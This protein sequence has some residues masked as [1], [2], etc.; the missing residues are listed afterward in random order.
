MNSS[1]CSHNHYPIRSSEQRCSGRTCAAKAATLVLGSTLVAL[2]CLV[3]QA[4]ASIFSFSTG[5]P[6]KKIATLSRVPSPAGIQTE[7]AD[8]F[9]LDTNT[10]IT[11][12]TFTGLIPLGVS[13]A[14]ITEVEIEIYHVFPVDSAFPPSGNVPN[15]TNSPS[16]V[17][18]GSA[19]RDSADGSLIAHVDLLNPSFTA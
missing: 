9:I 4:S 3:T 5:N 8:D 16:D 15:R 12:A 19:T 18:I 2:L 10:L 6:D 11:H 14:S 17:E 1:T 13:L 7:T